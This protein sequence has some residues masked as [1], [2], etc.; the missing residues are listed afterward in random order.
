MTQRIASV[1]S[2][3]RSRP[4][5]GVVLA[6]LA[7][8]LAVGAAASSASAEAFLHVKA[9]GFGLWIFIP[10]ASASNVSAGGDAGHISAATSSLSGMDMFMADLPPFQGMPTTPMVAADV[11][12][13]MAS[14]DLGPGF[15]TPVSASANWGVWI[16][17]KSWGIHIIWNS[18]DLLRTGVLS[19]GTQAYSNAPGTLI[20][21]S[22]EYI[23]PSGASTFSNQPIEQFEIGLPA[24]LPAPGAAAMLGLGGLVALRRRRA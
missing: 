19:D 1:R 20:P 6:A 3:P 11:N 24:P 17:G 12:M 8:P 5:L 22:V 2:L 10:Y 21:A 7:A 4:A 14:G 15:G 9:G 16:T 23:D 13:L 18:A